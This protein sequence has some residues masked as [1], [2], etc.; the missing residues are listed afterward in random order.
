MIL[1]I[2]N[3]NQLNDRMKRESFEMFRRGQRDLEI[4]T[5]DEIYERAKFIVHHD[6]EVSEAEISEND[7]PF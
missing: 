6:E 5:F 2:G 4:L 7:C 1:I 3:T